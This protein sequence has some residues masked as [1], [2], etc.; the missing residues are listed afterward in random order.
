MADVEV[1]KRGFFRTIFN[2]YPQ[3]W[4]AIEEIKANTKAVISAY[5]G[6]FGKRKYQVEDFSSAVQRLGLTE[7]TLKK[8]QQNFL[9]FSL[10]YLFLGIGLGGY[11]LYL[12]FERNLTLAFFVS[13]IM[14]ILMFSYAFKEHFWY[15]QISRQKLG[16]TF[17]EWLDFVLRRA[18]K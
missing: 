10:F 7:E 8:Q 6:L 5:K 3:R 12:L 18:K 11:A 4:F 2:F 9:Y 14:S 13:L 16:C 17:K 15:M 1:K